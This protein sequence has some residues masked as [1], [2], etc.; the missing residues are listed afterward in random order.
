MWPHFNLITPL[1]ALST[2]TITSE[3]TEVRTSAYELGMEGHNLVYNTHW[4]Q[5]GCWWNTSLLDFSY[6]YRKCNACCWMMWAARSQPSLPRDSKSLKPTLS[7]D[8][9]VL[10]RSLS[11]RT[12]NLLKWF[13][14]RQNTCAPQNSF[15]EVLSPARWYL[16]VIRVWLQSP[17]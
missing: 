15:V 12:F 16:Q 4:C 5:Q 2:N 11:T 14:N 10:C 17:H 13:C 8:K 7:I 6:T 3:T 1:R 9:S